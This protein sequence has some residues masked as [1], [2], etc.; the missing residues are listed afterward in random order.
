MTAPN[1]AA[2]LGA[3]AVSVAGRNKL[4]RGSFKT[5][6]MSVSFVQGWAK[7]QERYGDFRKVMEESVKEQ[8][9]LLIFKSLKK[10]ISR[11]LKNGNFSL[12]FG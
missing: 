6:F 4:P 12:S 3:K 8:Q 9:Q 11:F 7:F 10:R 2:A 1:P 5:G